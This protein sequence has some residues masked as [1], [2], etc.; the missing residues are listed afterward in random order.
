MTWPL[1]S[2]STVSELAPF[3]LV[4]QQI[5]V[6]ESNCS[7]LVRNAT[8]QVELELLSLF[9]TS[10][11][12]QDW[13]RLFY[14]ELKNYLPALCKH[15]ECCP[16]KCQSGSR[17]IKI[18]CDTYLTHTHPSESHFQAKQLLFCQ[19]N[20]LWAWY[21][22]QAHVPEQIRMLLPVLTNTVKLHLCCPTLMHASISD[23]RYLM[24]GYI[25]CAG[26]CSQ[27]VTA[28]PHGVFLDSP[29]QRPSQCRSRD[30]G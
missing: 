7:S 24:F 27:T 26:G 4:T 20:V 17:W 13:T 15:F 2:N 9:I 5:G 1:S 18:L 23:N 10:P 16:Q 11:C 21:A 28:E 6:A 29:Q 25:S 19:R 12:T 22:L 30:L 3:C 8:V 14:S